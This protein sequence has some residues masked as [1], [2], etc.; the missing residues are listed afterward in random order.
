MFLTRTLDYLLRGSS[1]IKFY[2]NGYLDGP[3]DMLKIKADLM[4]VSACGGIKDKSPRRR[5]QSLDLKDLGASF[6]L[7]LFTR[8]S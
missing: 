4:R 1:F 7:T 5:V 8:R 3:L 2:L 6:P